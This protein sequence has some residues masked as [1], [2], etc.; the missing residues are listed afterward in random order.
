ML[1]FP[2]LVVEAC[3]QLVQIGARGD[4]VDGHDLDHAPVLLAVEHGAEL[5]LLDFQCFDQQFLRLNGVAEHVVMVDV[6]KLKTG[7]GFRFS[8][9]LLLA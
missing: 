9:Q 4:A 3:D 8:I 2:C 6:V 5:Q 7:E 1:A